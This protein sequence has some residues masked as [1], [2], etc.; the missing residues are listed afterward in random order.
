MN[1]VTPTPAPS[2]DE[3]FEPNAKELA[4]LDLFVSPDTT[5]PRFAHLWRYEGEG[6]LTFVATDGHT[7]VCRRSGDMRAMALSDIAKIRPKMLAD[8][9]WGE[10]K[11]PDGREIVL[12]EWFQVLVAPKRLAANAPNVYSMNA[13]YFSRIADI[14]RAVGFRAAD[15]YR[16][17][18]GAT[19]KGIATARQNARSRAL[20]TVT[21]GRTDEAWYFKLDAAAALWEGVIMPRRM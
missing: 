8:G 1:A 16:P 5:R 11:E 15:D 10:A 18:A 14:E 12:P 6:G 9:A 17:P 7:L 13:L 2:Q 20:A 4:A 3:R 21:I 19:K